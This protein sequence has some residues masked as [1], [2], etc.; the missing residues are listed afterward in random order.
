MP[1]AAIDAAIR[2]LAL[3]ALI[4]LAVQNALRQCFLQIVEQAVPGKDLVWIMAGQKLVQERFFD[5]RAIIL[6]SPSAWPQAQ[7]S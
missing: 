4:E 6:P 5:S 1:V 7:N 2:P 3:K